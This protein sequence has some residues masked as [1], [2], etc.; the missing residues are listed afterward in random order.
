MFARFWWKINCWDLGSYVIR[1]SRTTFCIIYLFLVGHAAG[2]KQHSPVLPPEALLAFQHASASSTLTVPAVSA[3]LSHASL[4][5]A[6]SSPGG[7]SSL[8][9]SAAL[10]PFQTSVCG[11]GDLLSSGGLGGTSLTEWV[12]S[13]AKNEWKSHVLSRGQITG[14]NH[15]LPQDLFA[16][17]GF[18]TE[19]QSEKN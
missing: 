7:A 1:K 10:S 5:S 16:F 11:G 4:M 13:V 14:N 9:S 8:C 12:V 19:R 6:Q 3:V 15:F 18:E 17:I 2:F